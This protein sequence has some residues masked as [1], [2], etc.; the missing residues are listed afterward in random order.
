MFLLLLVLSSF[1]S[2]KENNYFYT[3]T[4]VVAQVSEDFKQTRNSTET[5]SRANLTCK[6]MV[7]G[8]SEANKWHLVKDPAFDA[9][10]DV[11]HILADPS[12]EKKLRAYYCAKYWKV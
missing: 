3:C 7:D 1:A 6:D 4:Q 5:I 12:I 11:I 8:L 10:V 9:C 2:D